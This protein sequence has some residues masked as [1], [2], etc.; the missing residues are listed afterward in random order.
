MNHKN[1]MPANGTRFNPRA[2]VFE[3]VLSHTPASSG[4]ARTESRKSTRAAIRKIEKRML[5]TA[6]ARGVFNPSRINVALC[7]I[8]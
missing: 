5:A 7:F 2:T 1:A 6:A 3:L 8:T 4:S